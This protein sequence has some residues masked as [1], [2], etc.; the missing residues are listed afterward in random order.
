MTAILQKISLFGSFVKFSHTIFAL[1]FA[2]SMAAVVA[3]KFPVSALQITWIL[4]A[5]VAAR[6]AAM[7]FNRIVDRE[8]D[9]K[10]PRT[11]NREI[12]SGKVSVKGAYALFLLSV[13]IFH[14]AAFG[15]GLHCLV[16]APLVMFFLCF[17][18]WT[19]RF[20]VLSHL[21]LGIALALAPG[22]VWYSL[23]GVIAWTPIYMMLAVAFWVAG[24]DIIYSCQ[25]SSF[26]KENLLFSI[27]SH[28]G[29]EKALLIAQISHLICSLFLFLFGVV[30]Q[31]NLLYFL[32]CVVFSIILASQHFL[33]SEKDLS[34]VNE[35]FFSR[36]GMASVVFLLFVFLDGLMSL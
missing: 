30:S 34:K 1:P 15:L 36:N 24:F 5:L 12:P 35:A 19:K 4:V 11:I 8:I 13:G 18:S 10:N 25:D 32:G 29:I 22:G 27:P 14:L 6:T 26:D 23:T 33:L 2:L 31:M 28:F 20:T 7:S 16:L 21:V 9:R 17:Y 3:R